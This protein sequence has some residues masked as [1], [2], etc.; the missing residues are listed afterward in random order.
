MHYQ[1]LPTIF[2]SGG[3]M[4][5]TANWCVKKS[6]NR[7]SCQQLNI[8]IACFVILYCKISTVNWCTR[9]KNTDFSQNCLGPNVTSAKSSHGAEGVRINEIPPEKEKCTERNFCRLI[10]TFRGL[11]YGKNVLWSTEDPINNL[12]IWRT[13]GSDINC[14]CY[15][16][17]KH[18]ISL[19]RR[20]W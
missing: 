20:W 4:R 9:L 13:I 15:L 1:L 17:P 5:Q 11:D 14:C 18:R 10:M 7:E 16:L 6:P 8:L 19:C 3:K 2:H 12:L